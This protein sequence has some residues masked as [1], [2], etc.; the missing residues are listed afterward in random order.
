MPKE[1]REMLANLNITVERLHIRY[2]DDY[3]S[4]GA[5]YSFGVIIDVSKSFTLCWSFS[6]TE[7]G[8]PSTAAAYI[9]EQIQVYLFNSFFV[10]TAL[11]DWQIQ[12]NSRVD[13]SVQ[14]IEA[15]L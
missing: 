6:W 8:Q 15:G 7:P 11:R 1:V 13:L 3:F 9:R 10:A 12:G 4:E 5:P 14:A 2:E